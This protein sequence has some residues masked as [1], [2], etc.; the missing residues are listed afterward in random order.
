MLRLDVSGFNTSAPFYNI[1]SDNPFLVPGDGIADEIYALGL[2]NPWRWSFDRLNGNM[3][4]ADV[5]QSAWEEVNYVTAGSTAGLNYGWRCR[6]G[7]HDYNVSGCG[8]TYT[9]PIFDYAH[10]NATGGFSIT[11][12][13]VYRG[14]DISNA[15]LLGSYVTADYISGNF[16]I[17]QP[18]GSFTI[19]T[20]L[21]ANV[22]SFGEANDGTLY[23]LRRLAA[24]NGALYKLQVASIVPVILTKFTA[25]S[26]PGYTLLNWTTT[27]E[28]NS[29]KYVPQFSADNIHFDDIGEV[30][31]SGLAT[32][33]NYTFQH[34]IVITGTSY[35]RL[36][37]VDKD[38]SFHYSTTV[39]VVAAGDEPISIFPTLV[40]NGIINVKHVKPGAAI[41]IIAMDGRQVYQKHVSDN[42][43]VR[44]SLPFLNAGIYTVEVMSNGLSKQ[45]RI[46][47]Q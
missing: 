32:G 40:T 31:A 4:I 3:W 41:R 44:C 16:W 22:V 25:I 45:E 5:G 30:A 19:Q 21:P 23:L 38:G 10:N 1:P 12:G 33:T 18:N 37:I 35:Y 39:H 27:S 8:G 17:V 14:P 24:P 36:A 15:S 29:Q 6:E 28:I 2:R 9:E 11:G 43:T 47:I 7:R 13:Y 26:L 34:H 42:G 46:I 20:G